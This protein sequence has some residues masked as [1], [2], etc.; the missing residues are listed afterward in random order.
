MQFIRHIKHKINIVLNPKHRFYYFRKRIF[1]FLIGIII[2]QFLFLLILIWDIPSLRTLENP[3]LAVSSQVYSRDGKLLGNFYDEQFR[4]NIRYK[5]LPKT[6]INALIATEDIRFYHHQGVDTR[7]LGAVFV[8][9]TE[10][11][12]RGGS[13]IT[14]QLAR[15]LFDNIGRKKS[16]FRKLR[17]AI[18]AW[19]LERNYSKEEIILFYFNTVNY[20]GN[21]HGIQTAAKTYFN[22]NANELQPHECA[23]LVGILKGPSLYHPIKKPQKALERRNI[24]LAQ[25]NKYGYLSKEEYEKYKSLPLGVVQKNYYED[26]VPQG[27]ALYF[28]KALQQ[29]LKEWCEKNNYNLYTDGLKI[30]TTLDSRLQEH[31]E[32]AIQNRIPYLQDLL[33][34][35]LKT[36]KPWE[37]NEQILIAA[38]KR[39]P[40]YH[41]AKNAGLKEE[42]IR[43]SFDR[44]VLMK[45]FDWKSPNYEKDTVLTPWDSLKYYA[46][47]I[48]TGLITIDPSNGHILAYVGG[49]DY[50]FFPMDLVKQERRQAGTIFMPFVY[51]AAFEK[52]LEPCS[53]EQNTPISIKTQEGDLWTPKN[54]GG[55]ITEPLPLIQAFSMMYNIV[56]TRLTQKVGV[57]FLIDIAGKLG[58]TSPLKSVPSLGMGTADLNLFELVSAY[59]PFVNQGIWNQ[60]TFVTKIEDKNG[61][62]LADFTTHKRKAISEKSA[63][64]T[65]EC[66]RYTANNGTAFEARSNYRIPTDIA[67][68]NGRTQSHADSWFVGITPN[69]VTA[70]W[71]GCVDRRVFFKSYYYGQGAFMCLPIW[72]EFMQSAYHD[73]TINLPDRSFYKNPQH[74]IS[75]NC[76]KNEIKKERTN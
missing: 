58:I 23:L 14:M 61:N 41:I 28:R 60:T 57:D 75:L 66:L 59:A 64:F 51:A 39:S 67:G 42:E 55:W 19:L 53:I 33:N 45:V 63:R 50:R 25:L 73:P 37:K 8:E 7:A 5:D 17:E 29:F 52:G 43:K 47:L 31:A 40:R 46:G 13:T 70:I 32:R 71:A 4:I 24:V 62:L 49:I 2:I 15:N 54:I 20:G 76:L 11:R 6:L 36:R 48:H 65:L 1:Q 30:Y 21:I 74:K 38:M 44:H 26:Y 68:M 72:G 10:G 16:I 56:V 12:V 34:Q 18:V 22:K 9:M 69:M 27:T 35:E 3:H